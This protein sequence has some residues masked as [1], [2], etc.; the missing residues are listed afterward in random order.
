MAYRKQ[1][2]IE[3][4]IRVTYFKFIYEIDSNDN[5]VDKGLDSTRGKFIRIIV[6]KYNNYFPY[7]KKKKMSSTISS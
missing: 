1:I 4:K 6:L 3:K 2:R 5:S 7:I